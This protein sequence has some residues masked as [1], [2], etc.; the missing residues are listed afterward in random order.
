MAEKI[1]EPEVKKALEC[2]E[3]KQ[4]FI[5]TGGAGSGKT[6]SLVSLIEEIGIKYPLKS[7]VCI[8]YTNN[9][10]A[11]IRER[12]T[13]KNL[14]VSTIHEFI[15][16]V[17]SKYQN[18]I[19]DTLVELINTGTDVEKKKFKKPKDFNEG[20]DLSVQYFGNNKIE[21]DEYYSLK[22]DKES[23]ISHDHIL[24]L[25]EKMFSK[26]PKLR[27]I[28]K[29]MAN[30]IF[31]DEYQD[32]NPLIKD[33]LL[34]HLKQS[35]K[36]FV[37]G[38]FGDS[39]QAIYADGVGNIEDDDLVRI[40]KTQN[41]RNPKAVIEL[42]NNLRD[43]GIVQIPSNDENAK[44]MVGGQLVEGSVKFIYAD[45]I[46]MLESLRQTN[47]FSGWNFKNSKE[48]KE[49]WLVHKLNAKKAEFDKLY[50]LYNSDLIIEL[51]GKIKDRI[52][53]GKLN[54]DTDGKSFES[55]AIEANVSVR[56]REN[57][58]DSIKL[59]AEYV[60]AFE[61]IKDKNWDE[62]CDLWISKDSLL[63]YKFNGLTGSYEGK[64]GRD[65]ILRHLDSIYELIELYKNKQYNDFLRK[66]K[67]KI[68]C[69]N[70][71]KKINDGMIELSNDKLKIS[72]IVDKA[73]NIFRIRDDNFEE[74][75]NE[76]GKYLWERIKK[77]PF[78]EYINSIAYQKE[79]LPFATQHSIK[80]S[81]F[82]NVLVVLD[83]GEWN[84]YNFNSLFVEKNSNNKPFTPSVVQTTRKLFYV[85]CTRAM[86]NLVIFMPTSD[87][88]VIE[89]AKELFGEENVIS[90]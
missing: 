69:L 81:E 51:I 35:S 2:I 47:I 3:H 32:T 72:E 38:F 13:N 56:G 39:M 42:A 82:D 12:I 52:N 70:D 10:V 5:L 30:Y 15:W 33:I 86:K 37:V 1:M 65:K 89:K 16:S 54:I 75:I 25:A 62:V 29:D 63:S 45:N 55:I 50:E 11:E 64:S 60:V 66:T 77:L 90:G 22:N 19:K 61:W 44:N 74:Y 73:E 71:K 14:E 84:K 23:K 76:I 85:C 4:N 46:N 28:L 79:Y 34:T 27:D 67:F 6:Y 9:A 17:I 8:T 20:Q 88:N 41:R 7:V 18:E 36:E 87:V 26:Y 80:G 49:L 24:I 83:N 58:L 48:T 53:K 40:N 59:N 78:S 43:D 57:L 68:S 21:Y 31:V